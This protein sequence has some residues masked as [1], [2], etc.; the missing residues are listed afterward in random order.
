[1]TDHT[2]PAPVA[3]SGNTIAASLATRLVD[4]L[5]DWMDRARA[6]HSLAALTEN[7]LKDIG[8]SRGDVEYEIRKPFWRG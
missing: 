4:R 1:M 2:I 7:E 5:L 3:R 8:L 6:R